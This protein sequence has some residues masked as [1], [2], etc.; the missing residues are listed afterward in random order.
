M[1]YIFLLAGWGSR[2]NKG[3]KPHKL[4]GGSSNRHITMRFICFTPSEV[5][6]IGDLVSNPKSLRALVKW[7]QI[8]PM[9]FDSPK[10]ISGTRASLALTASVFWCLSFRTVLD[11]PCINDLKDYCYPSW[12]TRQEIKC[13]KNISTMQYTLEI[14]PVNRDRAQ[15]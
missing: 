14:Q 5:D 15:N 1:T 8:R 3:Q 13:T 4:K 11:S 10:H 6:A 9:A 7:L 12:S 2:R